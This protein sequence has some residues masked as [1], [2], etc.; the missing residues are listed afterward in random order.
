MGLLTAKLNG[1][2]V[3]VSR[4]NLLIQWTVVQRR[5]SGERI[6]SFRLN[7]R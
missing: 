2:P 3:R 7:T 1:E 5:K 6:L 4:S